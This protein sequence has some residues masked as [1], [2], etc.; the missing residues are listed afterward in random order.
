[1][2]DLPRRFSRFLIVRELGRGGFGIVYLAADTTLGRKV[3]LKVP[4]PEV[5]VT[6]AVRRRFLREAEAASRLDHPHIVPVYEVGEEGPICYIAS[7]F[8]E[9][10]TLAARLRAQAEPISPLAAARMIAKLAGAVEHAHDRGILHRD[11]KPGNIL[12]SRS[13]GAPSAS[14]GDDVPLDEQP[15][16]CDFGLAKLLDDE[17]DETNTGFPIGSPN[18]MSPEQ[19]CGRTREYGPATDIHALGAILYE[20]LTGRPPFR[21]E[22]TLETLRQ[23]AEREPTP[24]RIL[25]PGL[26]RD[27]EAICLKCLEKRPDRRYA[28]AGALADDLLRFVA[29]NP[30]LTRPV[31]PAARARKWVRRHPVASALIALFMVGHLG[32]IGG[33]A[34]NNAR[35]R[36]YS[37]TV[38]GL[39][40][41]ARKSEAKAQEQRAVAERQ[42]RLAQRHWVAAQIKVAA[43]THD[44]GEV[45]IARSILDTLRPEPGMPDHRAFA[46]SYLDNLCRR[47]ETVGSLPA[48][49]SYLAYSPDGRMLALSDV[50][51]GSPGTELEFAL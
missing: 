26:P 34:W 9:G 33:L 29:G 35:E 2:P 12:L 30:T 18:Y 37:A 20:L 48:T 51:V 16:I 43:E 32:T 10:E 36:R 4:R 23:V 45:D 14:E 38:R 25:R 42:E 11:L 27:L 1:M 47:I 8:C 21:G 46:W 7:A 44:R 50:Q 41:Q 39:Y 15:R 40:E 49:V 19:A 13:N 24:P 22:S 28:S 6:P 31:T 17:S 3:A 5:L